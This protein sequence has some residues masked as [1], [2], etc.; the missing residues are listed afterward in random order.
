MFDP[1]TGEPILL[2]LQMRGS[3][4]E[5]VFTSGNPL[6]KATVVRDDPSSDS[7]RRLREQQC[8]VRNQES[9]ILAQLRRV[10]RR[11]SRR[12]DDLSSRAGD[13]TVE[14]GHNSS[15]SESEDGEQDEDEESLRAMLAAS[16]KERAWAS[17]WDRTQSKEHGP[18]AIIGGWGVK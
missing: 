12:D 7:I 5:S 2:P 13:L 11:A 18:S 17:T 9:D 15:S 4:F 6:E 1:D 10:E 8:K 3:R 14:E 16:R